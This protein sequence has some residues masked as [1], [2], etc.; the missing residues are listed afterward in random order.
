MLRQSIF[1]LSLL[2]ISLWTFGCAP[3]SQSDVP[4][5]ADD[6]GHH[7]HDHDH[8][9]GHAE[10]LGGAVTA[11][12]E[13]RDGVSKAFADGDEDAAHGPLHEVGHLLEQV[14]SLAASS[15][16]SAEAKAGVE[17]N[18]DALFDLFGAVDKKMHGDEEGGKDYKD[19]SKEIDAAISA[20]SE[21]T[22]A[23]SGD[24]DH[25]EDHAHHDAD[26]DA[27]HDEDGHDHDEHH[28]KDGEHADH[29]D[30]EEHK[31]EDKD[32]DHKE[33]D[34]DHKKAEGEKDAEQEKD[35]DK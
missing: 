5:T 17:K 21:A 25:D 12:T 8:G 19:V 18:V 4:L 9:H 22:A 30:D 35:G 28:E 29:D 34:N 6:I 16:L 31:D 10:T 13:L 32:H 20:I 26:G 11:L 27:H 1:A 14:S 7:D 23:V 15:E 24:H 2:S 3:E 33:G